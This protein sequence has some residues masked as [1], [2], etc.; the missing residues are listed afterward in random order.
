MRSLHTLTD[1]WGEQWIT[2]QYAA[3]L[4]GVSC[5]T[6]TVM[7]DRGSIESR[8]LHGNAPRRYVRL[9]DLVDTTEKRP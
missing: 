3:D 8:M 6:V 2:L 5:N 1:T 7:I 4:L 9:R